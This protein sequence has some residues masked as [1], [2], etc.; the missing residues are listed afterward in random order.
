MGPMAIIAKTCTYLDK[1]DN[2]LIFNGMLTKL[3][4]GLRLSSECIII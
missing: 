3:E 4:I 1:H 2:Q